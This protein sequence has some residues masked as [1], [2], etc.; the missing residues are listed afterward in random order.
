MCLKWS[1]LQRM[2]DWGESLRAKVLGFF[3]YEMISKGSSDAQGTHTL[4]RVPKLSK[5]D[6]FGI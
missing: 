4:L 6:V 2:I 5:G 1:D 3:L